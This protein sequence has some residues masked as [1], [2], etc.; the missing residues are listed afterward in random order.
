MP[1]TT[2]VKLSS[3]P[4]RRPWPT[5][6]AVLLS[7]GTGGAQAAFFQLAENSPAG[8]GNA[9]AGGAAV[10]EDAS[11]VWFNPAGLT[12]LPGQQLV[13]GGYVILPSTDFD[14]TSATS[15]LGA[16]L[17][18][19]DGGNAGESALLPNFYY[20]H[21]YSDRLRFGLGVNVPFGL[22]TDYDDD[23][24]GRYHADRSEIKTININPVLAY[25]VSEQLSFGAGISYQ[26]ID[27]QLSQFVDFAT[28]CTISAGGVF[29]GA[30]GAGAGFNPANN[31]NDGRARVVADDDAWG[32]NAGLLWQLTAATRFGL[33]YR[34]EIDYKLD[35]SIDLNAPANVPAPLRAAAGAGSGAEADVTLPTTVSISVFHE[36]T[37]VWAVMGDITRT[38]WS[39]L[40]SLRID[41]TDTATADDSVV[42]LGLKDVNRYSLG[43][44]YRPAGSWVYRFGIALDRT[45]TPN[46]E[47]RTPRLPDEDRKWLSLGAGYHVSDTLSFDVAYT[48]I[49][50]DDADINKVAPPLPAT[51]ENTARGNLRGSY[52]ATTHIL[53]AQLNWK[54]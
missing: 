6:S 35:G 7:L 49:L 24:V 20:A 11:T 18:G 34:S 54:F 53:G 40:P 28:I 51:D 44:T 22:A 5:M 50:I 12:R 29:S 21:A 32:F 41:F 47:L 52:D 38:Y 1:T 19:G 43:A 4:R 13:V 48:Y 37:P 39:D 30:C 45:P 16:P 27:A 14:K 17:S 25:K 10:A 26:K 36:L 23:W 3:H 46:P 9:F 15:V 2:L 31:P 42:T 8:L 33:H